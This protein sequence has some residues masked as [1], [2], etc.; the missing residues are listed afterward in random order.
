MS[1]FRRS[2]V[3]EVR[4]ARVS[5]CR[6]RQRPKAEQADVNYRMHAIDVTTS[7]IN[8]PNSANFGVLHGAALMSRALCTIP[9]TRV[10][11]IHVCPVH[12]CVRAGQGGRAW[13]W[14]A[15]FSS[16]ISSQMTQT[17][18]CEPRLQ[19]AQWLRLSLRSAW[20][21]PYRCR[22]PHARQ[23]HRRNR[24]QTYLLGGG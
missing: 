6:T 14:E 7:P 22:S 21:T 24:H 8:A 4:K 16:H 19:M 17:P 3:S 12:T 11:C 10:T 20:R 5:H 23:C 1:S 15:E 13:C 18:A 9:Y 2:I